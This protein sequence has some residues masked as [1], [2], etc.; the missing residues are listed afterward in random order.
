MFIY[1]CTYYNIYSIYSCSCVDFIHYI[2]AFFNIFH[3]HLWIYNIILGLL[4]DITNVKIRWIGLNIWRSIYLERKSFIWLFD[5]DY[6]YYLYE[7][8]NKTRFIAMNILFLYMSFVISPS[9]NIVFVSLV[10]IRYR[11]S[12]FFTLTYYPTYQFSMLFCLNN[13]S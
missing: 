2:C 1:I 6:Y 10:W 3:V 4:V 11:C 9:C 5:M 8:E 13:L 7:T 12:V